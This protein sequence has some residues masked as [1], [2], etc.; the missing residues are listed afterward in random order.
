MNDAAVSLHQAPS[1]IKATPGEPRVFLEVAAE[2]LIE[3]HT[4]SEM[5]REVCGILLGAAGQDES[6]CFTDESEP[7]AWHAGCFVPTCACRTTSR[8]TEA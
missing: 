6:G 1:K 3:E 5:N 4:H 7:Q 2:R 8:C